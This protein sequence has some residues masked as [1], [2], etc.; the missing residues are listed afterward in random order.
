MMKRHEEEE[1]ENDKDE[2]ERI[3]TEE[4]DKEPRERQGPRRRRRKETEA[5]KKIML[6]TQFEATDARR[7]FPCWDE[8]SFRARFQLTVIVPENFIAFSNMPV[9]KETK[10]AGG[11]EIR[12]ATTPPM[13][14]Y[15]NVFCAGELETLSAKVKNVNHGVV[16]T[17]GKAGLGPLCA[18]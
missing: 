9:E 7:L 17:M 18:R 4:K 13:A 14:S 1:R 3:K 2:R 15:L 5:R 6:G 11:K 10:V 12:F 16:T 8:P